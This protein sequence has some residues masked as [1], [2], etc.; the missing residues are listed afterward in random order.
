MK[1]RALLAVPGLHSA[2]LVGP[3]GLAL[4]AH[5]ELG[6]QLAAEV[7]ALRLGMDRSSRR[8]GGGA[9]TRL[10]FTT[11]QLE[12]VAVAAGIHTAALAMPRGSDTRA[13][14]LELARL[15]TELVGLPGQE[16]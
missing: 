1:L 14:Q 13:A 5:G 10:A 7:A 11:E 9:L 3:D 2:A 16:A 4:E 15:A 6:E 12:V 8:L